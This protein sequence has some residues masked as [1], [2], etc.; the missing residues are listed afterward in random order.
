P[1]WAFLD[2]LT[3]VVL[4][5]FLVIIGVRIV[6]DSLARLSD[7]APRPQSVKKMQ[8]VICAING[9]QGFHAFRA[10]HSGAGGL[11]EMDV[12]IQVDPAIT[13]RQGHDIAS[14]VERGLRRA[15]PDVA[16]IVVHIEPG[17]VEDRES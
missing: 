1:R 16:N 5:A 10:R 8:E 15:I 9:V 14:Q 13:V 12:H 2:H 3:A 11:I 4:A 7:R 6:R 17:E